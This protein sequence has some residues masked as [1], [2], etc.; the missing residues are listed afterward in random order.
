MSARPVLVVVGPTASGKTRAAVAVARAVGGVVLS[1]DARQ[2]YRGLDVGSGKEGVPG[3]FP[4]PGREETPS[5]VVEGVHQIGLD[6]AAPTE[7][8]TAARWQAFASRAVEGLLAARVPFV[9]AGGTGF[10][11][12]SLVRG[13]VWPDTDPAV[14]ARYAHLPRRERREAEILALGQQPRAVAPAWRAQIV[15]IDPA[16]EAHRAAIE[17]RVRG[18]FESGELAREVAALPPDGEALTAIGY[19]EARALAE[20]RLTMDAAIARAVSRTWAYARRQRAY[21]ARRLPEATVVASPDAAVQAL[22]E[23]GRHLGERTHP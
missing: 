14:R 13:F 6:L 16:R 9:V 7:R 17:A 15:A 2:V 23:R 12:E 10:Y 19:A 20:R 3:T 1:A 8:F 11:V 5:R 18:W 22:L 4:L 21:V